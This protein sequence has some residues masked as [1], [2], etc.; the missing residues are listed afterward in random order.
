MCDAPAV[1]K[2]A[3]GPGVV[4]IGASW[5][6]SR[7]VREQVPH[8]D[9]FL[10]RHPQA[11]LRDWRL[12]VQATLVDQ[13]QDDGRRIGLGDRGEMKT[14]GVGIDPHMPLDIGIARPMRPDDAVPL[15]DRSRHAGDVQALA[16]GVEFA[17]EI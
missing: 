15:G 14:R 7:R 11:E 12:E 10:F 8:A 17:R 5:F 6:R 2:L 3:K 13:L 9:R 16:Q 4:S 1:E